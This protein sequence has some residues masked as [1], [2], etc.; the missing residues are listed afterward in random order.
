MTSPDYLTKL[1][2]AVYINFNP[3]TNEMCIHCCFGTGLGGFFL[4]IDI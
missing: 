4:Y 2:H 1:R 3:I